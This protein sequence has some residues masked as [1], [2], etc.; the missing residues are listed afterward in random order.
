MEFK[1]PKIFRTSY[2]YDPWGRDLQREDAVRVAD[3]CDDL[4]VAAPGD[5][6]AVGGDHAVARFEPGHLGGRVVHE[7]AVISLVMVSVTSAC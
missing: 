6:D 2:K 4:V 7:G 5:V 3:E 1:N